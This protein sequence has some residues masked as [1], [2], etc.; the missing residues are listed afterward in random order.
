MALTLL[1]MPAEITNA[2]D[3]LIVFLAAPDTYIEGVVPL[4]GRYQV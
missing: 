2:V 1:L 3:G 4:T